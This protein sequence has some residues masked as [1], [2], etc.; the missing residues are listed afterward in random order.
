MLLQKESILA[1]VIFKSFSALLSCI[2]SVLKK[3]MY[4][5]MEGKKAEYLKIGCLP[6]QQKHDT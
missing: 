5:I 6:D 1:A 2:Y 4:K 3:S